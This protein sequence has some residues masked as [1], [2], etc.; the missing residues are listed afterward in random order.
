[1]KTVFFD[2]DTQIDFMYPAGALYAPGA[3]RILPLIARL[4]Q[5]A[6]DSGAVVISS[7]DAHSE[8]DP[9]F[10]EWPPH[11]VVGTVGQ[12]KPASTLL[13]KRIVIPTAEVAERIDGYQQILL[14]K[15]HLDAFTNSNLRWILEALDA[16]RYVVYGVVTE[17]CVRLAAFGLLKTGKQV[18]IVTDAIRSLNE[19]DGERVLNEFKAAG[20]A[21][22]TSAALLN[23]PAG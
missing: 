15:Q 6:A 13:A 4:N 11:C 20:G 17:Y 18:E 12:Q 7:M 9:E 1:M 16:D 14:E 10:R 5:Q 8:N 21:L 19:S 3:E 22:T 23:A 2:V